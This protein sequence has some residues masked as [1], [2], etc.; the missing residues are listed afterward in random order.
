MTRTLTATRPGLVSGNTTSQSTFQRSQPS[1][2][3]ASTISFGAGLTRANN[4][5]VLVA[6][7]GSGTVNVVNRSPGP[8]HLIVDVNG[9][10]R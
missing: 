3:A 9:Y 5:M 7:D 1:I 2:S 4:A 6:D 10:F 8:L